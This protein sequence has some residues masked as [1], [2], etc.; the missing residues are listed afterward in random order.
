M[1]NSKKQSIQTKPFVNTVIEKFSFGK[2]SKQPLP[3]IK[4]VEEATKQNTLQKNHHSTPKEDTMGAVVMW[5]TDYDK[6]TTFESNRE[7]D[8]YKAIAQ[9]M[10]EK[11]LPKPIL[12]TKHDDYPNKLVIIDGNNSFHAR[13]MLGLPIPYL[14]MEN[15]TE[16]DMVRLNINLKP[17]HRIDYANLYAAQ[18]ME[19]YQTYLDIVAETGFGHGAVQHL[20]ELSFTNDAST[21]RPHGNRFKKGHFVIPNLEKSKSII[22]YLYSVKEI[23]D[24]NS[25]VPLRQNEYVYKTTA[26]IEAVI[27]LF[28]HEEFDSEWLL[29]GLRKNPKALKKVNDKRVCLS[30]LLDVYRTIYKGRG[31]HP[32]GYF[33]IGPSNQT[34]IFYV[35]H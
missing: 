15:A 1:E 20:L 29:A 10:K 25:V 9:S 17:W 27:E 8:H 26:F 11:P 24:E 3:D 28:R 35:K 5:T 6:F 16:E 13:K 4:S 32:D 21:Q 34:N 33:I 18:G 2:Q 14:M 22:K 23:E 7:P 31:K 19:A 12:V 30:Y